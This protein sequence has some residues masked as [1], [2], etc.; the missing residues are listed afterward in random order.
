VDL[1]LRDLAERVGGEIVGDGSVVLSGVSGIREARAG[2]LTFLANPKYERYLSSTAATAVIVSPSYRSVS[3]RAQL[4]VCENAYGAFAKAMALFAPPEPPVEPGVDPSAV[5][6]P[7]ARIGEGVAVG[8]HVTV[9]AGASVGEGTRIDAGT[10][11]GPGVTVGRGCT[12]RPNVTLTA[13]CTLGDRVIVHSGSVIGSDGFGFAREGC[14]HLKVPQIG[15]VVVEDDVEIGA[16]VCVDRATVGATRIGRGTK[17]DNLVQIGH[18]VVIG[19]DAI[20]VAQVGISGSTR[21]GDGVVLAGQVGVAGHIEIGDGAVVGAQSGVTR[22]VP[23]GL[24]V[25]GYPAQN[26]AVSKRILACV[27][28]LPALFRRVRRLEQA[29]SRTDKEA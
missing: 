20:I 24:K 9:G 17:I 11:L 8:P 18:N 13:A 1:T 4:L 12:I 21:I 2:Q 19:E 3:S 6:S 28:Q 26:H 7:S 15:T 14:F 25:S 5:V 16:N 23:A 29:L 22:P 10:F 27:Q